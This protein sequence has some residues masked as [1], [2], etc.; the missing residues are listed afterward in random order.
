[1]NDLPRD[2]QYLASVSGDTEAAAGSVGLE[3]MPEGRAIATVRKHILGEDSD[4][5]RHAVGRLVAERVNV[6]WVVYPL[7]GGHLPDGESPTY[8]VADDGELEQTSPAVE[9]SDYLEA[10]ERRF[11]LRRALFG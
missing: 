6:G 1:M 3:P 7:A 8:Y 9:R 2:R 11:R 10:F 5:G 4:Y